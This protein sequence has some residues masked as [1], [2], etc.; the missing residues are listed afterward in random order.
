M[1]FNLAKFNLLITCLQDQR[2]TICMAQ[3]CVPKNYDKTT[4]PHSGS[5]VDGAVEV[6]IEFLKLEIIAVDDADFSVT[7]R[8]LMRIMWIE[9]RLYALNVTNRKTSTPTDADNLKKIWMTN[10]YI[11]NV[12]EIRKFKVLQQGKDSVGKDSFLSTR[13]MHK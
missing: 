9:P 2:F 12:K 8:C 3:Y 4:I 6:T 10:F 11:Y 7:F 5:S 1:S 13:N